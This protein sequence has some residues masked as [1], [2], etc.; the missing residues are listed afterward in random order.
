M[1]T[2]RVFATKNLLLKF[3]GHST[4]AH[5]SRG[6]V[7]VWVNVYVS[8]GVGYYVWEMHVQTLPLR[9]S[10]KSSP[11]SLDFPTNLRSFYMA[12]DTKPSGRCPRCYGTI[13]FNL[14]VPYLL[15]K[16]LERYFPGD[17]DSSLLCV[18]RESRES[19]LV[20]LHL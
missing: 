5:K 18:V 2:Q 19:Y 17:D 11:D 3:F 16:A 7:S 9:N 8:V 20:S 10:L 1:Y 13:F 14:S 15:N 6:G 12:L 4:E